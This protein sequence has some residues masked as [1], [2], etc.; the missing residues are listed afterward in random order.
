MAT[1]RGIEATA[2]T[3][4]GLRNSPTYQLRS[5]AGSGDNHGIEPQLDVDPLTDT[6]DVRAGDRRCQATAPWSGRGM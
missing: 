6:T 5:P 4:V 2:L 3:L 1:T